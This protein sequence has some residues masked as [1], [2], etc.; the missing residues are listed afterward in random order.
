[1]PQKPVKFAYERNFGKVHAWLE[2]SPAIKAKAKQEKGKI[3]WGDETG[4]RAG[5]VRVRGYAPKG[6]TPEE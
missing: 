6:K 4:L 3:D 1:M 2:E 5:D